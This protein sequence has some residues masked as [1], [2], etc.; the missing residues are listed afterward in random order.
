MPCNIYTCQKCGKEN[1]YWKKYDD[2]TGEYEENY[3]IEVK[4]EKCGEIVER[5]W[6][7]TIDFVTGRVG[8]TMKNPGEDG[9]Y[10][11]RYSEM[12]GKIGQGVVYKNGKKV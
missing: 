3:P 9:R 2:K 4:C 5:G 10:G 8:S 12:L 1:F 11:E 6:T 7:R